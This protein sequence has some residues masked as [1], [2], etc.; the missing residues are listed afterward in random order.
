MYRILSKIKASREQLMKTG[1]LPE[2]QILKFI[3]GWQGDPFSL[4]AKAHTQ[5]L[6]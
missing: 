4:P 5:F 3:K 6:N 1:K 2:K